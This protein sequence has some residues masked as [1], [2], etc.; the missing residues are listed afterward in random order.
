MII[1]KKHKMIYCSGGKHW[2]KLVEV[3]LPDGCEN[4]GRV[5]CLKCGETVGY[6]WDFEWKTLHK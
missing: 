6:T 4:E 5:C 2:L 3:Y 1:N